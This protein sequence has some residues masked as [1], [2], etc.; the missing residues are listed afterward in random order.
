MEQNSQEWPGT[1]RTKLIFTCTSLLVGYEAMICLRT[2]HLSHL[3]AWFQ[4][5]F[6]EDS[7]IG[8]NELQG[9]HQEGG[10]RRERG[11]RTS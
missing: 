10:R 8:N 7:H 5:G 6:S 3:P 2:S 11:R 4:V 9:Q 1:L